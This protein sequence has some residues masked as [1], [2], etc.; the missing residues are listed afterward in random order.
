[1]GTMEKKMEIT[2][3]SLGLGFRV[4]P[5]GLALYKLHDLSPTVYPEFHKTGAGTT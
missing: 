2:V 5:L 4:H 3:W 1:M